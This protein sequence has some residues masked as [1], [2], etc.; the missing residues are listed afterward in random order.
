MTIILE[1]AEKIRREMLQG[2][3]HAIRSGAKY[4]AR[5]RVTRANTLHRMNILAEPAMPI[6]KNHLR[7]LI[8]ARKSGSW[9][10]S[11]AR[12]I[13]VMQCIGGELILLNQ[14]L[15]TLEAAE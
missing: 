14:S 13:A 6:L 3:R 15:E 5:S 10:Y 1:I 8:Q 9:R 12:Y 2:Q 11:H 4:Y 7:A